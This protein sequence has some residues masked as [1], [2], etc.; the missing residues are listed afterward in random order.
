VFS[1]AAWRGIARRGRRRGVRHGSGRP[2]H[3]GQDGLRGAVTTW[4]RSGR[5]GSRHPRTRSRRNTRRPVGEEVGHLGVAVLLRDEGLAAVRGEDV[6]VSLWGRPRGDPPVGEP[7]ESAQVRVAHL[8]EELNAPRRERLR[9]RG[10]VG[11]H[12]GGRELREVDP[13]DA[14]RVARCDEGGLEVAVEDDVE[15]GARRQAGAGRD[16][17]AADEVEA[18]RR[19]RAREDGAV[20]QRLER[21][22]LGVP[23]ADDVPRRVGAG[24]LVR[25]NLDDPA[26]GAAADQPLPAR[27][28]LEAPEQLARGPCPPGR[29][30]R[31]RPP[32]GRRSA[33]PGRGGRGWGR[34]L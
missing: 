31:A 4:M 23:D 15:D 12:A 3:D 14:A 11:R 9:V 8:A 26:P 22:D 7:R 24:R 19:R 27:G 13:V 5:D 33:S 25:R 21:V 1:R 29:R 2:A 6:D 28:R 30:G 34:T 17:P 32:G 16:L 20:G 10:S 18:A